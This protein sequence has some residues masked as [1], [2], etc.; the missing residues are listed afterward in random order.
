MI[1]SLDAMRNLTK[2][3]EAAPDAGYVK[4]RAFDIVAACDEVPE[5]A[6]DRKWKDIRNG[7]ANAM[8]GYADPERAE[9]TIVVVPIG[10]ARHILKLAPPTSVST[11]ELERRPRDGD[12]RKEEG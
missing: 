2:A 12:W 5:A 10:Y 9:A 7:S 6:R 4:V 11:V 3:N 8:K 1:M